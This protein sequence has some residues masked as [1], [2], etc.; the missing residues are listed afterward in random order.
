MTAALSRATSAYKEVDVTARSPLE[1]VVMLYDGA[2]SALEQSRDAIQQGDLL[3]K[4]RAMSKALAIVSHLQGTLNMEDGREIAEELDRLYVYVT[5]RIVDANV[6]G[7]AAALDDAV[8]VLKT[9]R[10]AWSELA[11][12][13]AGTAP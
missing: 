2:I 8:R 3:T 4:R 1:L 7:N 9:L 5:D 13:P 6:N 11:V 10:E 12:R